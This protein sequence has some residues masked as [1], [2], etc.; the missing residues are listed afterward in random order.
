M[1]TSKTGRRFLAGITMAAL[2]AGVATGTSNVAAATDESC[3]V[4]DI[5]YAIA[6]NLLVKDTQ[7]GAANGVYPL[8]A[9]KMRVRFE[10]GP[11]GVHAKLLSYQLDNHLTIKASVAFWWTK[12]ETRSRTLAADA[13]GVAARGELKGSDVVWSTPV[14]GYHSDGS[15]D[16]EGNVCGK[17]GAPPP[18]ESELHEASEDVVFQPFH[19]A[20]DG[21]TF[22]MGF[23]RVS[24]SDSPKQ[25]TFVGLSGRET[26]RVCVSNAPA[27]S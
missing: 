6:G 13:G 1:N 24:H 22:T 7:F 25:T 15:I 9:G 2:V 19:F 12:V 4:T 16:C 3:A 26:R 10:S 14:A 23:S 5:D 18:G 11:E 17:Y 20:A 21:K 8:G 27:S